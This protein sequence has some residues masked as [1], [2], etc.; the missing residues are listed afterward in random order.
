M[1]IKASGNGRENALKKDDKVH[2]VFLILNKLWDIMVL[3]GGE[4]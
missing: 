1:G 4:C 3:D 2:F